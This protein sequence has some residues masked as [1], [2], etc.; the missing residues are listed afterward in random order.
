VISDAPDDGERTRILIAPDGLLGP[1]LGDSIL[2]RQSLEL[3]SA[4]DAAQ[5]LAVAELWRPHLL[6]FRSELQSAVGAFYRSLRTDG[7]TQLPKLIMVTDQV[8][9]DHGQ[10]AD[11]AY[12]AHLIGPL[13]LEELLPTI[14]ELVDLR[15]RRCE[16]A[17]IDV[18]VHT[19]GFVEE[20]GPFDA[21][22]GSALSLSEDSMLL[23]ASRQLQLRARGR[24]QF[25]LPGSAERLTLEGTVRVSI[26]DVRLIYAIELVDLAPQHR[27][28]IRRYVES[29]KAAA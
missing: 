21:T 9:Q 12:D 18:L 4:P 23:E 15:Q 22:L 1:D 14:A 19:E 26:D 29:K 7:D 20:G 28:A 5:A 24:L 16:R 17:P 27:A 6:V 8:Q 2:D 25:F 11:A 13:G 3:R 10:H